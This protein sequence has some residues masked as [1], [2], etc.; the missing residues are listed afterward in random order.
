MGKLNYRKDKHLDF[1]SKVDNKSLDVLVAIITEDKDGNLRD[2]E[3]LTLQDRYKQYSPDHTK[4]WDLIAADYQYFGGN[5][6][7]NKARGEGVLYEEILT[8]TCKDMKVDFTK[9]ASVE[10][11]EKELLSKVLANALDKMSDSEKKEFLDSVNY[12]STDFSKQ[13][14]LGAIQGAM[15]AGGFA[16]YQLAVVVANAIAK[17]LVGHGLSLATN[18]GLVKAI[19]IVSGPIGWVLTA[20][21]TAVDL[22]G[23]AKR[24]TI[25]ATIYIAALRQAELNRQAYEKKR[26]AEKLKE[27]ERLKAKPLNLKNK[28]IILSIIILIL[29]IVFY[30]YTL[31]LSTDK[32][33]K[34]IRMFDKH[35]MVFQ[36]VFFDKYL[37]YGNVFESRNEKR[38]KFTRQIIMYVSGTVEVSV[39]TDQ[40]TFDKNTGKVTYYANDKNSPFDVAIYIPEKNIKIVDQ[41]YPKSIDIS[42]SVA[43]ASVMGIAGAVMGASVF[44]KGIV[45]MGKLSS[46]QGMAIGTALGGAGGI[47]VG[48]NTKGMKFRTMFGVKEKDEIMV[49]AEDLIAFSLQ[50]DKKMVEKYKK[51]FSKIMMAQVERQGMKF[52]GVYYEEK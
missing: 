31:F 23:P 8:D 3:D 45:P 27:Y 22:A 15:G 1:L 4:Y 2:S 41:I 20:T 52:S 16:S 10:T 38:D 51:N 46:L 6:L 30:M 42:D 35:Q 14:I 44:K 40:L 49:K 39:N 25:P 5:T 29:S 48:L 32:M 50:N 33:N 43:I 34:E 47:A 36:K 24:V 9:D 7:V 13:A 18:A 26:K 28:W 21:W 37:I 19:G 11:K 17:Q 12:K